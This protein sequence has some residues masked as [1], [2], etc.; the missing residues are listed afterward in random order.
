MYRVVIGVALCFLPTL[1]LGQKISREYLT[2]DDSTANYYIAIEPENNNI[3]A[4]MFVMDGFGGTP[5]GLLTQTDLPLDAARKGIL[6]ILPVLSTGRLYFGSDNASQTSLK[7]MVEL[8]A[9]KYKLE[10]KSFYIGG[11]SIGGTCAVKYAELAIYHKYAIQP[12]AVFGVDPPLD[13]EQFYNAAKRVVRIL[14]DKPINGEVT[15][16]IGRIEKEMQGPP[17][18][19]LHNYYYN[20]PYSYSDTTQKAVKTLVNTPIKLITEPDIDWWLA[21]RGYDLT[22]MNATSL[23]AMIN[24]LQ[25]LGN[26]N[27][28]LVT[29][30][31]KGFRKPDM[32]RHPHSWSIVDNEELLQWLRQF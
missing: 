8:V 23:V 28:V 9:R 1:I 22:S 10:K 30:T 13:W 15:Y 17:Q 20:S 26:T 5:D 21:N 2:A 14:K 11:F 27:A 24:E 7:N 4:F 32:A 6:C 3:Q 29:T 16:M 25:R 12:K 31:N 19:A 18:T